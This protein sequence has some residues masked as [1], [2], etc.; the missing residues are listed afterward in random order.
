MKDSPFPGVINHVCIR[1]GAF[2][3]Y[4]SSV[5]S[6][7][8]QVGPSTRLQDDRVACRRPAAAGT[9]VFMHGAQHSALPENSNFR[10]SGCPGRT[11]PRTLVSGTKIFDRNLQRPCK[12]DRVSVRQCDFSALDTPH[13][14]SAHPCESTELGLSKPPQHAPVSRESLV[15]INPDNITDRNFQ[16]FGNAGEGVD[17]GRRF[18]RLPSTNCRYAYAGHARQIGSGQSCGLSCSLQRQRTEPTHHTATHRYRPSISVIARHSAL[19]ALRSAR[20]SHIDE[21]HE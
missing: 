5:R 12:A 2:V 21:L 8:W 19:S 10:S 13:H 3:S 1:R 15:R 18:T 20:M 4:R 6:P 9:G 17:L 14:S 7:L 11:Q 16:G